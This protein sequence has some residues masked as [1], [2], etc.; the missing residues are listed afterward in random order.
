MVISTC[1]LSVI[2]DLFLSRGTA[3][4]K[5]PANSRTT[6]SIAKIIVWKY[7]N[8]NAFLVGFVKKRGENARCDLDSLKIDEKAFRNVLFSFSESSRYSCLK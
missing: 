7:T 5:F 2:A 1:D 3:S 8:I 4:S 6:A